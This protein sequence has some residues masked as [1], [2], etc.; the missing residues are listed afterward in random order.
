VTRGFDFSGE[1]R[2]PFD[3]MNE[4]L[5]EGTMDSKPYPTRRSGAKMGRPTV[6]ED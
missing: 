2:V 6:T 3:L 1:D 5:W 4:V